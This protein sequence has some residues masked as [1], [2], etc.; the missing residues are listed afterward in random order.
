MGTRFLV[1]WRL[2]LSMLSREVVH[3][4][5]RM[6]EY[7]EPLEASGKVVERYHVV[8]WHGGAWIY[9]VGSNEELEILLAKSPVYNFAKF[10]VYPLAR[11]GEAYPAQPDEG[12]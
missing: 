1:L 7:A 9:E 12:A 2:E 3:A 6:P 11:M 10:D 5:L 4:V 8:G